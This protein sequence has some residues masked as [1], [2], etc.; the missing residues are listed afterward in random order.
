[1]SEEPVSI[2]VPREWL[3]DLWAMKSQWMS[4]PECDAY[5]MKPEDVKHVAGCLFVVALGY[6]KAQREASASN[7]RD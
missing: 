3:R 6:R 4:C 7:G 2:T 5:A 1:M